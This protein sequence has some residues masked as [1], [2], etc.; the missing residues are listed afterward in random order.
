MK[1]KTAPLSE[2]MFGIGAMEHVYYIGE[3][4]YPLDHA[5]K[6]SLV[7]ED[8]AFTGKEKPFAHLVLADTMQPVLLHTKYVYFGIQITTDQKKNIQGIF[9]RILCR[10]IPCCSMNGKRRNK[11]CSVDQSLSDRQEFQ[12]IESLIF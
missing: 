11:A 7:L 9:I 4:A 5:I 8:R 6:A 2:N 10:S 12:P 3:Q 1:N